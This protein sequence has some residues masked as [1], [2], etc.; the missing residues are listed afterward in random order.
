MTP[1]LSTLIFYG[2]WPGDALTSHIKRS[3]VTQPSY[4][5]HARANLCGGRSSV[6]FHGQRLTAIDLDENSSTGSSITSRHH[7]TACSTAEPQSVIV[8]GHL[9]SSCVGALPRAQNA[10]ILALSTI[11]ASVAGRGR[12]VAPRCA[13]RRLIDTGLQ[14]LILNLVPVL[15]YDNDNDNVPDCYIIIPGDL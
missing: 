3:I 8:S 14:V 11:I 12:R 15:Q 1:Q 9:P 5:P 6:P 13:R 7:S 4:S 2:N 10:S